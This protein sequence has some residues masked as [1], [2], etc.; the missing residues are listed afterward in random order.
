MNSTKTMQVGRV[1]ITTRWTALLA[2]FA[3]CMFAVAPSR[4]SAQDNSSEGK[5]LVLEAYQLTVDVE[6]DDEEAF[7][8]V[9]EKCSAGLKL[10]LVKEQADYARRLMSWAH[11]R[12][13]ELMAERG[14][15]EEA[16]AEFEIAVKLDPNRWRALHNRGVS[17]AL[18]GDFQA[19][20]AD[21]EKALELQ[22]DYANAW[23]NLG[24]MRFELGLIEESIE[25]YDRALKLKPDDAD[26]FNSRGHAH[27]RLGQIQAAL[28]DYN[29]A[30]KQRPE[31]PA[32]LVN[33]ADALTLLG[34]FKE[35]SADY[36]AAIRLDDQFGRAYVGA[37]WM[38]ATCPEEQY[39]NGELAVQ[40]AKKALELQGEV[41]Y[42]MQDVLAA[43]QAETGDFQ[44][45]AATLEAAIETFPEDQADSAR[46]RLAL[47]RSGR[48]YREHVRVE[49]P[50]A[51]QSAQSASPTASANARRRGGR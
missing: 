2:A 19:G 18:S 6:D 41:D 7:D 39:R 50:T 21:V 8:A 16:A 12:R 1:A 38:M 11:N 17:R 36:R 23:Y 27:F 10:G 33:R 29:A 24:E 42:R 4:L 49:Q 44:A 45:A 32:T 28:N 35:A 9:I 15:S 14:E 34:Q 30:L 13:G 48:P 37:A 40:S 25:A 47:Y 22:P 26:A 3:A 20:V 31:D 5:Q 51:S 46:A 43:A